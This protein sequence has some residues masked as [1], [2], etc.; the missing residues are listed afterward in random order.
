MDL[1]LPIPK[2]S[3]NYVPLTRLRDVFGK[4]KSY[5]L[6]HALTLKNVLTFDK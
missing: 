4:S 2:C 5:I 1:F 3:S 6:L